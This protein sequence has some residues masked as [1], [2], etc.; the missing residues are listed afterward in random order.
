MTGLTYPRLDENA[1]RDLLR[2]YSALDIDQLAHRSALAHPRTGWYETGPARVSEEHL[3]GLRN[4]LRD[5][6]QQ[7][8]YPVTAARSYARFDQQAATVL[9][10]TMDIVPADA[11]HEGVW[12]F[13]SLV[14]LPDVAVW[15]FP[16]RHMDRLLGRPRNTFRRLWTRVY[17]LGETASEALLEDEVVN[18]MERP[19]LGGDPRIARAIAG[20]HLAARTHDRAVPRTE[21]LRD[22]MKR[23]RR[24]SVVL[25]L[26][27]LDN[28]ELHEL[29]TEVFEASSSALVEHR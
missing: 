15:R 22:A 24:M 16:D 11:A 9:F 21:L 12:T 23:L 17:S 2:E 29:L 27:A 3:N 19:S 6:A 5:L 25:T 8:G 14:L 28:G 7:H 18:I 10:R 1:A 13:L 4:S 26:A 20:T